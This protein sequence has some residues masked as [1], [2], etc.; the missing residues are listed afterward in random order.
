MVRILKDPEERKD[1]ILHVAE[2]LFTTKGYDATTTNDIIEKAGIARGTLYYYFRSKEEVLNAVIDRTVDKQ[3]NKLLET[4]HN[5]E[6]NTLQKFE[7]IVSQGSQNSEEH[8]DI[9]EYIHKKENQVMHQKSLI[10]SVKKF[11]PV[12]GEIIRQGVREGLFKT[13]FSLELSEFIMVIT[14]FNF[15]PDIFSWTMEEYIQRMKALED[16]L[17]T[18]LRAEKGSFSFMSSMSE[19]IMK[20]EQKRGVEEIKL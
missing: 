15:D 1:E 4:L 2:I 5:S 9:V 16:M 8:E 18:T 3:V 17:E 10:Q 13:E 12:I 11:S 19:E 6:L 14:S 20:R 7:F